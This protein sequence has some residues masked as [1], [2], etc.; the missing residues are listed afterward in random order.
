MTISRRRLFG[1]ALVAGGAGLAATS[2][3]ACSPGHHAGPACG[4]GGQHHTRSDQID[5]A[6]L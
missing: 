3:G 6:H 4:I 5:V 1:G 2:L